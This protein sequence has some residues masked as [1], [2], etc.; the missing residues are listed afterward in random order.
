MGY[1]Q[2]I[3]VD[4]GS[5]TDSL[6]ALR[7]LRALRPLRTVSQVKSLRTVANS[8]VNAVPMLLSVVGVLF[9]YI[10]VFA[11]C[12]MS[13]FMEG[14]H[15]RCGEEDGFPLELESFGCNGAGGRTCPDGLICLGDFAEPLVK[16]ARMLT[17]ETYPGFDNFFK[18]FITIFI[19]T[20]LEGWQDIMYR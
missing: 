17:P 3:N 18:S 2:F 7:A 19:A 11:I 9:F 8:F 15:H 12:G 13:V 20:T 5:G 16:D 6:R 14:M 10:V 4:G 1:S